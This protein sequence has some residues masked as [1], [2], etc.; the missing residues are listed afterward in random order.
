MLKRAAFSTALRLAQGFPVLA[1]TGPRQSGKT[2]LA[3][4]LFADKA[5]VTLEDPEERSFADTDPRGFLARFPQGAILDEVQRCPDLFSYLQGVVDKRKR[6]GEFIVTGSQQ[7]GL[8]SNIAQSLA[9]RVGLLQLL[10]FSL[11]ELKAGNLLPATLDE[12]MLQG[13]YPPLYDRP[14]APGDWFPNYVSTYLERDVRQL[15]AVRDLSL[16]QRFLKMCAA[17]S[18]QLLNLSALAADCGISHVTAREWMTVLE[19]SYI[20]YLLRPYHPNPS[21]QNFGKRLVKMPKLYFLDTGL[22]AYLLGIRDVNTLATHA[23]RGAL[24]ETLVVSEWIKRQFNAGQVAELYFWRDSAG[25]E[26]DL[27]IPQGN[28]FMPVEIKS[29]STFSNDCTAALRKLS[30]LFGDAALPPG[31]VYGGEGQ[32]EREGCRVVGWQA[33]AGNG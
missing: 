9:G 4:T 19:A 14:V 10:P 24:F 26:V 11:A 8:M 17:R 20:V 13:S 33:L 2:T 6:M 7:F 28:Q 16:F 31:I 15:L 21:H 1:I 32:Y 29:G 30:A 12:A 27:L 3:R 23:S 18:G 5:Y 22:M 25:H